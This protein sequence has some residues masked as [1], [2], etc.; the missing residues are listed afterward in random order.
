MMKSTKKPHP[1]NQ[2]AMHPEENGFS[3]LEILVVVVLLSVVSSAGLIGI[4]RARATMRLSGAAREYASYIEKARVHSVRHHAD[5]VSQAASVVIS[6][7]RTQYV[8]T[9]D[10]NGD[11]VM[12]S[13]TI[14]LPAGVSF[15]TTEAIAFDWRGRTWNTV[16]GVTSSHAQVS[17]TL[18]N[19]RDSVSVDVTGSGD[20]TIDSRVFDDAVPTVTLNVGDLS[21]TSTPAPTPVPTPSPGASP[22]VSPTPQPS[23]TASPTPTT[24]PTPT[25]TPI[26]LPTP[27]PTPT[28]TPTPTPTPVP[29]P[30]PTPTPTPLPCVIT[31]QPTVLTLAQNG[32]ATIQVGNS[33]S[34]SINVTGTSSKPSD[35]QVTP[36]SAQ[37]IPAAGNVNFTIKSKKSAGVYTV[38][39]SAG[40]GQVVVPVTVL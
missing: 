11:G 6:A 8:V 1:T 18:S 36:S 21:A 9:L 20:V 32:T 31:A 34:I 16:G 29:T 38:T 5:S 12:D 15:Q 35:L 22:S 28:A 19:G 7:D 14:P 10:F 30:T 39:F 17:I 27:T 40:C 37:T 4:A 2:R 25:P 3:I 23:P 33:S 13:R 26:Q 24:S